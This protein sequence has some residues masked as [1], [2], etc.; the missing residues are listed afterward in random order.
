MADVRSHN[1]GLVLTHVDRAG[2]IARSGLAAATGLAPGAITLLV[3][4]L[5]D[6]GLLRESEAPAPSAGPGRPRRALAMAG[7]GRA[8]IGVRF[9]LDEALVSAVDLGGRDLVRERVALSTPAGEPETVADELAAL[10][11]RVSDALRGAGVEP[12]RLVVVAPAPVLQPGETIPAAI[13]LGWHDVDLAALLSGRIRPFPLGVR[14]MNDANAAAYAEFAELEAEAAAAGTSITD[15]VYLKSDTGIGGGAVTGGALLR[16]GNGVA[17]EPGHLIVV[18]GGEL[19]LCG[20]RGCLVTVAGPDIVLARAGLASLRSERGMPAALAELVR[21]ERAGDPVA[22]AAVGDALGWI[23]VALANCV[24]ILQP[25]VVVVGGWLADYA[26][27]L[28]VAPGDGAGASR[29]PAAPVR[30]AVHGDYSEVDGAVLR[31]RRDL[32]ADPWRMRRAPG[33]GDAAEPV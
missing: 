17:F 29:I 1:V 19:C 27:R 23:E 21:R 4:E 3:S 25:Q 8:V 26:D 11:T 33:A 24:A 6:A 22:V 12:V 31:E 14:I 9:V 16:G 20:R 15:I 10:V 32:L 28:R 30:A 2:T 18:P 13:D 5:V 7:E